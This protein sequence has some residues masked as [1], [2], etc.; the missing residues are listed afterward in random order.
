MARRKWLDEREQRAWRAYLLVSHLLEENLDRQLQR[1]SG[2]ALSHYGILV[3][4]SEAPCRTLRMNDLA[5]LQRFSQ[6]RLTHAI[7][8]LERDGYVERHQCESDRR[9]QFAVLTP[10]GLAALRAAAPGH[11]AEVRAKVFDRLTPAQ[12]DALADVCE[13]LLEVLDLP[14]ACPRRA[15]A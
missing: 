6:S 4:L 9:G 1:D 14:A 11:V 10:S 5:S 13:T 8:R 12:V 15:E 7:A 2:M 3:A